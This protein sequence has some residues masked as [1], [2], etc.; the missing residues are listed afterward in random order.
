MGKV[1]SL[2][3]AIA[4]LLAAGCSDEKQA[5]GPSLP[6]SAVCDRALDANTLE[7]QGGRTVRLIGVITPRP[8]GAQEDRLG[9]EAL[10]FVEGLAV[11]KTIRLAYDPTNADRG[12]GDRFGRLLAYVGLPDGRDL[13]E[14]MI[15]RGFARTYPRFAS[16]RLAQYRRVQQRARA[17][18]LGLWGA[19]PQP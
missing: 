17:A 2:A 19:A 11:G 15:A 14:A 10:A 7:L 3:T 16:E 1:L 12:H 8:V 13:G 6:A 5:E 18:G 4:C 9:Q